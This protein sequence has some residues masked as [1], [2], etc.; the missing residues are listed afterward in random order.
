MPPLIHLTPFSPLRLVLYDHNLMGGAV[1]REGL[2][3]TPFGS[4]MTNISKQRF[5]WVISPLAGPKTT[6]RKYNVDP[7]PRC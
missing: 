3:G 7:G 4:D 2:K 5:G 6:F 1:P